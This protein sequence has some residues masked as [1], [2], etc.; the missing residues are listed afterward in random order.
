MSRHPLLSGI[1][2]GL[3]L[4]LSI[5]GTATMFYLPE[6]AQ[7][8]NIGAAPGRTWTPAPTATPLPTP[9]PTSA[10]ASALP[11]DLPTPE[12]G[13][14]TFQPG[15]AARNVN[16]GPVNMRRTPGYRNKP[17]NDR[18]TQVPANQQVTILSGPQKADGLIWWFVEW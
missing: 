17:A 3:I 5:V 1:L 2:L 13:N 7:T 18:I 15:D 14:W 4:F 11:P 10:P 9:T 16:N 8:L 6:M 12:P